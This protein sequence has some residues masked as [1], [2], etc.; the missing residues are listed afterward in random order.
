MM[1]SLAEGSWT[2]AGGGEV[3][4]VVDAL[5]GWVEAIL[6]SAFTVGV[7]GRGERRERERESD[8]ILHVS[9][10]YTHITVIYSKD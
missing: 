5:G 7:V 4:V 6:S 3:G 8:R 2:I 10:R 9:E 1:V